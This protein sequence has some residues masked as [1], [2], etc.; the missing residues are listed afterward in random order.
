MTAAP[1]SPH[2][3][4]AL[5]KEQ[6]IPGEQKSQAKSRLSPGSINQCMAGQGGGERSRRLSERAVC[7]S[8][9]KLWLSSSA[10]EPGAAGTRAGREAGYSPLIQSRGRGDGAGSGGEGPKSRRC[11]HGET[12]ASAAFSRPALPLGCPW[13]SQLPSLIHQEWLRLSAKGSG[14]DEAWSWGC[15]GRGVGR[16]ERGIGA[17]VRV[18]AAQRPLAMKGGTLPSPQPS[19]CCTAPAASSTERKW[20]KES[21][22]QESPRF[23]T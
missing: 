11:R 12:E 22:F 16:G 5:G 18:C 4:P 23:F 2:E 6:R 7:L 1:G 21:H 8:L 15:S 13:I 17:T 3:L 20:A 14:C 9:I 10:S 19:R